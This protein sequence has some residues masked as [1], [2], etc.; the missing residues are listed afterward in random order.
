VWNRLLLA[1]SLLVFWPAGTAG[2]APL[3]VPS[4]PQAPAT[5]LSGD[6][7]V[8]AWASGGYIRTATRSPGGAVGP[9]QVIGLSGDGRSPLLASAPNGDLVLVWLGRDGLQSAFRPVGGRAW[10]IEPIEPDAIGPKQLI[11]LVVDASGR[12]IVTDEA[13]VG[14]F[15]GVTVSTHVEGGTW[16]KFASFDR[17]AGQVQ[18]SA[19]IATDT[20]GDTAIVYL[21]FVDDQFMV[22]ATVLPVGSS[23]W[24]DPV[25]ISV[26]ASFGDFTTTVAGGGNRTFVGT[27]TEGNAVS[28]GTPVTVAARL[29]LPGTWEPQRVVIPP[30][31]GPLAVASNLTTSVDE[32]GNAT[33]IW[34]YPTDTA[35]ALG[36]AT[37]PATAA[38]WSAPE[39]LD[40][41]LELGA[42]DGPP[43]FA[44][45]RGGS[46][47]VAFLQQRADGFWLRVATKTAL[48]T[49]IGQNADAGRMST[50][51][52][53]STCLWE[54]RVPPSA[55]FD[56]RTIAVAAKTSAGVVLVR[57]T[58][59]GASW[60]APA[61]L[62][63]SDTTNV[64]LRSAHVR[65]GSVQVAGSC[66]VAFCGGTA[67]IRTVGTPSRVLGSVSLNGPPDAPHRMA[68]PSWARARLRHGMRL[69]VELVA[70]WY[71]D[72]G[73]LDRSSLIVALHA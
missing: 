64:Y 2:A 19:S 65:D 5:A 4:P 54:Q 39:T 53:S 45:A 57:G 31:S 47:A 9:S 72:G 67:I 73:V 41:P 32:N 49:W 27:W 26:L 20:A 36:I 6:R 24:S 35:S 51:S 21:T 61:S 37:L 11:K 14:A 1:L 38:V 58:T 48:G 40:Q 71:E 12:A 15:S 52:G 56:G 60:S 70:S 17:A 62:R 69:R 33:A 7:V 44:S 68:L 13:N 3:P 28:G 8:V 18:R 46:A 63:P 10:T 25:T 66:G 22:R 59:P 16:T 23:T 43:V 50:C 30:E 42:A 55:A 34:Q 29:R